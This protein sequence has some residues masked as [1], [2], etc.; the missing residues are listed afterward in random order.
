M[1]NDKVIIGD[2]DVLI[3]S[4]FDGDAHHDLVKKLN[5]KIMENN[6]VLKFPNTAILEAITMLKRVFNQS[7]FSHELNKDYLDGKYNIVYVDETIQKLASEIFAKEKSKKNTIFDAI[8]LAT[9]KTL[10]AAGIFS[11]DSWYKKQGFRVLAREPRV[12]A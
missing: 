11:F 8:V 10:K 2:A 6:L 1:N 5:E 9:A 4:V 12:R 7:N 3:A